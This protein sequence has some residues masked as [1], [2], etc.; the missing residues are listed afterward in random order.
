MPEIPTLSAGIGAVILGIALIVAGRVRVGSLRGGASST[1]HDFRG[2]PA[3]SWS[4]ARGHLAERLSDA[5]KARSDDDRIAGIEEALIGA[6]VGV[7]VAQAIVARI[8]ARRNRVRDASDYRDV[9]RSEL[10]AALTVAPVPAQTVRP[11]VILVVGVNGVGK[12]TTVGK[13]A[14]FYAKNNL[15]VLLVA[16]DTF[17]AAAAEQLEIWAQ[18]VGAECV[19]HRGS[20]SPASVVFDG[21]D[22][23]LARDVDVVLV[24]T[25]GRLH[26]KENLIAELSKM[27][28]VIDGRLSGAP[29]EV[30]LVVDA[31]AGQNALKQA[32]VF[33]E[34]LSLTGIVL[35]KLDGTARGGSAL[36]IS[37]ELGLPIRF[38]GFGE[39]VDDLARFDPEAF[40]DALLGAR[41]ASCLLQSGADK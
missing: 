22:A 4:F 41:G 28:R 5:W 37:E 18:R 17:R 21:I 32:G 31:T 8:K 14:R 34:A 16:A 11:L 2:V 7:R 33:Q 6:D 30:F 23:A 35:T 26:V 29:H 27:R 1:A 15:R 20:T 38:V 3:D 24:D 12:T 36:A 13:L 39:G 19:R 10:L 9:L 40:V 25:A